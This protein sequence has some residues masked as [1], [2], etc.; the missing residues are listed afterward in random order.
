MKIASSKTTLLRN[1]SV[2][3]TNTR[4]IFK[5]IAKYVIMIKR[6]KFSSWLQR[7]KAPNRLYVPG[8][9]DR[10]GTC[11][12]DITALHLCND[13]G[14]DTGALSKEIAISVRRLSQDIPNATGLLAVAHPEA[15]I[16]AVSAATAQ[17]NDDGIPDLIVRTRQTLIGH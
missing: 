3:N 1:R 9:R 14:L 5:L 10:Q 17:N 16:P 13:T 6:T 4:K 12:D 8:N 2:L 15:P 11:L 7:G